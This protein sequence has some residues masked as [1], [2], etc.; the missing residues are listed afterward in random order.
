MR[1]H[2]SFFT[3]AICFTIIF[4]LTTLLTVVKSDQTSLCNDHN[5]V[6]IRKCCPNH[7]AMREGKC[8]DYTLPEFRMD[9]YQGDHVTQEDALATL[10]YDTLP[11]HVALPEHADGS[12]PSFQQQRHK[13]QVDDKEDEDSKIGIPKLTTDNPM[14][15]NRRI[16]YDYVDEDNNSEYDDNTYDNDSPRGHTTP[17][18]STDDY[19]GEDNSEHNKTYDGDFFRGNT[20]HYESTDDYVDEYNIE[21]DSDI[22]RGN[23][24]HY[25]STDVKVRPNLQGIIDLKVTAQLMKYRGLFLPNNFSSENTPEIETERNNNKLE[26]VATTTSNGLALNGNINGQ[27]ERH[28]QIR[29]KDSALNRTKMKN[30]VSFEE[31]IEFVE[32]FVNNRTTNVTHKRIEQIRGVLVNNKHKLNLDDENRA[33]LL[34]LLVNLANTKR[35]TTHGE[36]YFIVNLDSTKT[37]IENLRYRNVL[38]RIRSHGITKSSQEQR[39][40]LNSDLTTVKTV[41]DSNENAVTGM[42]HTLKGTQRLIQKFDVNK[43]TLHDFYEAAKSIETVARDIAYKERK[44]VPN[45]DVDEMTRIFMRDKYNVTLSVDEQE[46]LVELIKSLKHDINFNYG[47]KVKIHDN[48]MPES[49]NRFF[50]VNLEY[51]KSLIENLKY[52]NVLEKIVQHRNNKVLVKNLDY[53]G[54]TTG[55]ENDS[56]ADSLNSTGKTYRN[57][58]QKVTHRRP[59]VQVKYVIYKTHLKHDVRRDK[60]N[61]TEQARTTDQTQYPKLLLIYTGE[62]CKESVHL[63]PK[64]STNDTYYISND[65]LLHYPSGQKFF[66]AK[67]YCVEYFIKSDSLTPMIC[68]EKQPEIKL[69]YTIGMSISIICLLITLLVYAIIPELRNLHGLCLMCHITSLIFAYLFLVSIQILATVPQFHDLVKNELCV[70]FGFL[71][72]FFFLAAFFWL[73]VMCFDIW[74]TFSS[75]FRPISVLQQES[76]KFLIYSL[77]AWSCPTALVAITV[78]MDSLPYEWA[79]Q[80]KLKP[81]FGKRLCWFET[82]HGLFAFF[83][84]PIG[85]LILFNIVMFVCTARSLIAHHKRNQTILSSRGS[86]RHVTN[87]KERLT[88]YLK[89]FVVMGVT[90]IMEV[91]SWAYGSVE[92]KTKFWFLWYIADMGNALQGVFILGIFLCK[93]RILCLLILKLYPQCTW[94]YIKTSSNG[95]SAT[96]RSILSMHSIQSSQHSI[97]MSQKDRI[98]LDQQIERMDQ[99]EFERMYRS[100]LN[101]AIKLHKVHPG[102][103]SLSQKEKMSQQVNNVRQQ[104]GDNKEVIESET[105]SLE[106][107][108]SAF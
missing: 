26:S 58:L 78:T 94:Q 9:L 103:D 96:G 85:I 98:D 22:F 54:F 82:E 95:S 50:V 19:V 56:F 86:K 35:L 68:F 69:S 34:E 18:E 102:E 90:W 21:N 67:D 41:M 57:V 37:L 30:N 45:I 14:T 13:R 74:W 32:N 51:T 71:I 29:R 4:W 107:V 108:D 48:S 36:T 43:E 38:E 104:S 40:D 63:D 101:L 53:L 16:L 72:Q 2:H 92:N 87:D 8:V 23:T 10:P 70:K 77:Y 89:L 17:S 49:R 97:H 55:E 105:E 64:K 99:K 79:T 80:S 52:R 66:T 76:K 1:K 62:F 61:D 106:Q 88:L 5:V 28:N 25:E 47:V 11:L 81:G 83:Y 15:A 91:L 31:A 42:K 100:R 27:H 7:Q 60:S 6:C 12:K 3:R 73:N 46:T 39:R 59:H 44:N 20:T 65:A 84:G 93:R 24:T 75:T 33:D